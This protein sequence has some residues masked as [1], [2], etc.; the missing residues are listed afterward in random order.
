MV[1]WWTEQKMRSVGDKSD[2]GKTGK[3]GKDGQE[4]LTE[5]YFTELLRRIDAEHS[6]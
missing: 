6:A 1:D 5:E 3:D 4:D 2:E